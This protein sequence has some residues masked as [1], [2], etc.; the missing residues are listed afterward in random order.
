MNAKVSVVVPL[1]NS[2]K[3]IRRCIESIINQ[4][5]NNVE[6]IIIDDNSNDKSSQ[7]VMSYLQTYSNIR[8]IKTENNLGPSHCRNIGLTNIDSKYVLFLDSDDWIDLNC[9]SKAID[10]FESNKE[11]DVVVWEIKTAHKDFEINKRYQYN[12]NNTISNFMALSLLSHSFTNEYFLSPLLGCKLIKTSLLIN[13]QISFI[14][15]FYEDD[16]F[17]FLSLYYSKKIG[18]VTGCNL[19]YYQHSES[20]T[21]HFNQKHICDLFLSF[22]SL[23]KAIDLSQEYSREI[24][25]KYMQ[26]CM[27][28]LIQRMNDCVSSTSELAYYKTLL[29]D[30]FYSTVNINEYYKYCQTLSI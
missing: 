3:Y 12:Y 5:Y 7:I 11:I 19:Y 23:Y 15:T 9:I 22:N 18:I 8:Y 1:Y 25:Y 21:H 14:D 10:K 6:L 26:K 27:N 30:N 2:E 4:S 16:V 13:N 28:S 24:F 20:L 29:L 17:T